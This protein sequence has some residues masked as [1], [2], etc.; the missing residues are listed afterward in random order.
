MTSTQTFAIELAK[1]LESRHDW[2]VTD[3]GDR[4]AI[5][6]ENTTE[7]HE[8]VCACAHYLIALDRSERIRT[9]EAELEFLRGM[10]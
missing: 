10:K 2:N 9:L 6:L 5:S 4:N 3:E 1:H 7:L 8:A